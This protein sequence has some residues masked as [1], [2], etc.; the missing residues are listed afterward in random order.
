MTIFSVTALSNEAQIEAAVKRVY[1]NDH[2]KLAPNQF[3]VAARG[4]SKDVSDALDISTGKTG[5][6]V[7]A[8]MSGY[9]GYA[10]TN[11]W[12]WIKVKSEAFVNG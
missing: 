8:T 4:T 11:I 5:L 2:F 6:G 12:E 10:P 9:F 3:L 1:P 7:I